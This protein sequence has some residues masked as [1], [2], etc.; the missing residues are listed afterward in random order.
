MN[1]ETA[2]IAERKHAPVIAVTAFAHKGNETCIEAGC[3]DHISKPFDQK[4]ILRLLNKYS[5]RDI[6]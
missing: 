5:S 3:D 6:N 2:L 4:N 1:K